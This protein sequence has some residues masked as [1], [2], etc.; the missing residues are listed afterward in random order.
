[1]PSL[2]ASLS[3][4]IG[5]RQTVGQV[6]LSF[7]L[8][9]VIFPGHRLLRPQIER[10]FFVERYRIEKGIKLLLA[11]LPTCGAPRT[12]LMLVGERIVALLQPESCVIYGQVGEIY[13]PVFVRG[14]VVPPTFQTQSPLM[15]V[16]QTRTTPVDIER[17]QRTARTSL[18]S[19]DR[20]L[21]DSLRVMM[22]LP[23]SQS[24]PPLAF[25]CLGQKRSGDV[26]TSA[27]FAL[28]RQVAKKVSE[29]LLHW[30]GAEVHRQI[31]M[32]RHTLRYS[33]SEQM[34]FPLEH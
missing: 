3:A 31:E 29:Q 9:L 30:E 27:D 33:G 25:F 34:A 5:I 11:E 6:F 18:S 16:L 12:L 13:V 28:L 22:V 4:A 2:S 17:W 19:D 7:F 21:L 1:M 8:A 24:E 20:A 14:S 15:G 32:M 26:Y 10:L 23:L